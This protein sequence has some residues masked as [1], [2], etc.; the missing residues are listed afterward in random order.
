MSFQT[1][2]LCDQFFQDLDICNSSFKTYGNRKSFSGP[3]TTVKIYDNDNEIFMEAIESVRPGSVIVL[4]G[5]LSKPCAFMGDR[6]AGI[7]ASRGIS[8]III[9]G[10]IRDIEG[11]AKLDIGVL[12]MGSHPLSSKNVARKN[13]KG[14]RDV[15]LDFGGIDWTPGHFVYADED[16]VVVSPRKF[17]R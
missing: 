3:I 7:A 17:D 4:D 11:L 9:N 2:D 5:V 10:Y 8:G 15:V 16:G 1:A 12:A 13:K 14:L 6:K